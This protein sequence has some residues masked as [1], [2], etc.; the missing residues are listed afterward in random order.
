MI[1][2]FIINYAT[3]LLLLLSFY[4]C[5]KDEENN[6][7]TQEE[8]YDVELVFNITVPET[9]TFNATGDIM[10]KIEGNEATVNGTFDIGQL[11]YDDL[12]FKG[13]LNGDQFT[14]TTTYYQVQYQFDGVTY[15]ED[16]T[17]AVPAFSISGEMITGGGDIEVIK[18]PG[19]T[20]ESGTF[21]F[22]ATKKTET[23]KVITSVY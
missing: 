20:T 13:S 12:E 17:L 19:N 11:S 7:S 6:P 10:L 3:V 14:L 2:P 23:E 22:S 1:N 15:T 21:T 18:N 9:Y 4:S 16:I 5:N 8:H